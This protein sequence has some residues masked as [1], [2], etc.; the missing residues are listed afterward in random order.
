MIKFIKFFQILS[1]I[2]FLPVL[3]F[4]YSYLPEQIILTSDRLGYLGSFI[5]RE[6]F[7]YS[8]LF[9][10]AISNLLCISLG[11]ALKQL[12]A[13]QSITGTAVFYNQASKEGIIAWLKSFCIILNSLFIF[14]TVYIG[15]LNNDEANQGT[16]YNFLLYIGPILVLIWFLLF[17][18]II[19]RRPSN[20]EIY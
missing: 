6:I 16:Q 8:V 7:F 4:V 19:I 10:F 17:V 13:R 14:G 1:I 12:P 9:L 11:R 5:S 3:I 18:F 20:K 15:M 2:A